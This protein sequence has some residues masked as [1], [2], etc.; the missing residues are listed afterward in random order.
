MVSNVKIGGPLD[1]PIGVVKT[2]AEMM[3]YHPDAMQENLVRLNTS[4][5]KKGGML[6]DVL[7]WLLVVGGVI[8]PTGSNWQYNFTVAM[9]ESKT[10]AVF[11]LE[12]VDVQAG[13]ARVASGRGGQTN[14]ELLQIKSNPQW[15]TGF[16]L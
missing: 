5:E 7:S 16:S 13:V 11:S 12:G 6:V 15:G 9:Q 8:V 10:K 14:W 4:G 2:I 3:G 1:M